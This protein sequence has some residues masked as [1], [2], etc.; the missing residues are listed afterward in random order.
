MS[1]QRVL[2]T[3][4]EQTEQVVTYSHEPNASTMT[5]NRLFFIFAASGCLLGYLALSAAQGFPTAAEQAAKD[6]FNSPL[7]GIK[8]RLY[9]KDLSYKEF[10]ATNADVIVPFLNLTEKTLIHCHGYAQ[11]TDNPFVYNLLRGYIEGY[12]YNVIALDYRSVTYNFYPTSVLLADSVAGVL[13]NVIETLV[14]AGVNADYIILSGFSLG[15]QIVGNVGRKLSFKLKEIIALDPAGPMFN[16]FE[17]SIS[18]SDAECVKCVHSDENNFGTSHACGHLDFYPNGG[19]RDQPGCSFFESMGACSHERAAVITAE[20]AVN[21]TGFPCIKCDSWFDFQQGNCNSSAVIP[22]GLNAP[23]SASGKY[24]FQTNSQQPFA[25]G[26]KG[27]R[28]D[29][30]LDTSM[31]G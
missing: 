27:I 18:A 3:H 21:K 29:S 19:H 26:M 14:K 13:L 25:R 10:S 6:M 20:A 31:F 4:L 2:Y 1:G 28:Y 22:Y 12:N 24:Y 23:C 5:N 9:K 17:P 30:S 11:S 7:N 15:A 16:L 8:L